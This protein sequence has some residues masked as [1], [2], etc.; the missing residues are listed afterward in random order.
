MERLKKVE[1]PML[2]LSAQAT[3]ISTEETRVCHP[4][5]SVPFGCLLPGVRAGVALGKDLGGDG[6]R[7]DPHSCSGTGEDK[8]DIAEEPEPQITGEGKERELWVKQQVELHGG[9]G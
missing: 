5:S 2:G 6:G 7:S 3:C 9:E 8:E 1:L 4:A